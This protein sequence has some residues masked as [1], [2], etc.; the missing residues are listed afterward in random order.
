MRLGVGAGRR[1]PWGVPSTLCTLALTG[2]IADM[3]PG[4]SLDCR[5]KRTSLGRHGGG[6]ASRSQMHPFG[7]RYCVCALFNVP[8]VATPERV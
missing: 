1:D 5:L 3:S 8:T 7:G 4:P 2:D 6:L